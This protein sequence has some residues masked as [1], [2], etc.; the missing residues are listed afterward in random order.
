MSPGRVGL[1]STGCGFPVVESSKTSDGK[2]VLVGFLATFFFQK[3]PSTLPS[4]VASAGILR[5]L[6][7]N[8]GSAPTSDGP[9]SDTITSIF[10]YLAMSAESTFCDSA[11]SQ[12]VTS[13]GCS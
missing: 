4:D 12:L 13:N 7:L 5:P 9:K 6:L 10:L 8:S 3:Q 11:G 2:C 1:H